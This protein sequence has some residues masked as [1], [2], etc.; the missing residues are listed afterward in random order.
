[1]YGKIHGLFSHLRWQVHIMQL[2]F[3][4]IDKYS[5]TDSLWSAKN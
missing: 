2:D 1:V 4:N 3:E 5:R